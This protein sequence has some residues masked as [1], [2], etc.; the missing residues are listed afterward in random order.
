MLKVGGTREGESSLPLPG[1]KIKRYRHQVYLNRAKVQVVSSEIKVG[2]EIYS[3]RLL[4][5]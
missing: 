3:S 1:L 4:L 5:F 2:S